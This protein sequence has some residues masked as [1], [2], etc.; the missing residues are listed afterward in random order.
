MAEFAGADEGLAGDLDHIKLAFQLGLPEMQELVQDREFG[1]NIQI[2][3]YIGLQQRGMVGDVV[4]DF[5]RRQTIILKLLFE[6]ARNSTSH[7]S[8]ITKP[9]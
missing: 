9:F 7:P 8:I 2:L 6:M 5:G 1:G 4:D 3:P